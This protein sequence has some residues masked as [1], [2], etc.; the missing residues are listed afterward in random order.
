MFESVFG[1]TPVRITEAQYAEIRDIWIG[2]NL[3]LVRSIDRRTIEALHYTLAQNAVQSV[4]RQKLI[5]ELRDTITRM[6]DTNIKRATLIACDQ[7][8]K[9]NSQLTQMEQMN[10]GVEEYVWRTMM[11]NRVRPEHRAR[12]GKTFRWDNPPP[13]GHPGWAVRC[14]CSA[15]PVY[16]TAKLG[17]NPR[18]GKYKQI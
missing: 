3:E 5:N 11:D 16:N 7:V 4:D 17:L 8:G 12:E 10:Q 6:T 1:A 18:K 9:L 13:D 15:A 2:Q 14:R